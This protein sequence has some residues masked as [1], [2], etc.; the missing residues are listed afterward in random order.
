MKL[1]D[2]P[3]PSLVLDRAA[4]AANCSAMAARAAK[5]G[6]RLRPHMKTAKSAEAAKIA[7]AGQFGGITVSTLAEAEYF[8]A[9]GFRD[10]AYAVGIAPAKL[11]AVARLQR[12]GVTMTLV[13][14]S[15]AAVQAAAKRAG[16]LGAAFSLLVEIETGG[17]RAGVLP[18]SPELLEVGRA[19]AAAKGLALAGVLTH[20]GN[21]YKCKGE[22]AIAAVAEEERAGAVRAAERL[23]A[24]GLPCPVVSVGAT[25]TAMFARSLAGVT[26]MR[27]GV[28]TLMDL[29]QMAIGVCRREDI[30]V[31]VLATVIGHNPR[32]GRILV[33][34]GALAL[35]HD[36]GAAGIMA[37]VGYGWVL[38]ERGDRLDG[39][40]VAEVNQEHGMIA[41]PSGAPP[42]E[43]LPVGARVR[44]LPNHACMM[45]APYARYN[46]VERGDE[47]VAVWDKA[48]GW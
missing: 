17:G 3:T 16:E 36:K 9:H 14:D 18:D 35:S 33:D 29:Y 19:I 45:A 28:Y 26:E 15:V 41:S 23:R 43:R 42:W 8:A 13:T 24:A 44:I 37:N 1:A 10:I 47:V 38:G 6:V 25:P 4:L 2:L 27:P 5:L 48:S 46:V 11:E 32:T 40:F 21:S 22:A 39:L 12:A 31:S 30:A 7:T 20:A 34:A